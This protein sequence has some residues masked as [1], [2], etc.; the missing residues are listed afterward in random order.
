[1]PFHQMTS[2]R[3]PGNFPPK[4]S[5]EP[6]IVSNVGRGVLNQ[7][8]RGQPYYGHSLKNEASADSKFSNATAQAAYTNQ[9]NVINLRQAR[10]QTDFFLSHGHTQDKPIGNL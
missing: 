10:H 4:L 1:M 8:Q 5:A 3:I 7:G 6:R 9:A 2:E